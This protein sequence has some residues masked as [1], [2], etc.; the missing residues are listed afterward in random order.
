MIKKNIKKYALFCLIAV[1]ACTM[2]ILVHTPLNQVKGG[3]YT[4]ETENVQESNRVGT[5]ITLASEVDVE[6]NGSVVKFTNG[7]ITYP[8]GKTYGIGK[9]KL[10]DI[11]NYSVKYYYKDGNVLVTAEKIILVT[12]QYYNITGDGTITTVTAEESVGKVLDVNS[13]NVLINNTDG[14]ILRMPEGSQFVY[15]VPIDLSKA[16]ENGIADIITL[17]YRFDEMAIN[18]NPKYD[19]MYNTAGDPSSGIQ[20]RFYYTIV[21]DIAA[22]CKIRLTDAY[23]P[24]NYIELD[25]QRARMEKD[26]TK[27]N[28]KNNHSMTMSAAAAGQALSGCR[29]GTGAGWSSVDAKINGN[30]YIAYLKW[31]RAAMPGGAYLTGHNSQMKGISWGYDNKTNIVYGK[32]TGDGWTVITELDN[33][34]IYPGNPFKGFT[35]GEVYLTIYC[36]T[37]TSPSDGARIDIMSINGVSGK[38]LINQYGQS[39]RV[40]FAAP[41]ITI[42]YDPTKENTIY[43]PFGAEV[44]LPTAFVKEIFSDRS[45]GINVYTN[46]GTSY[47]TLVSTKNNKLKLDQNKIYTVE[48]TATDTS[49]QTGKAYMNICPV[50]SEKAIWVETEELTSVP[51]GTYVTLPEFEIKT[52]NNADKIKYSVKVVGEKETFTFDSNDYEFRPNYTGKYKVI[53]EF[54]DNAYGDTYVYEFDSVGSSEPKFLSKPALPRYVIA[55]EKYNFNDLKAYKFTDNGT[56]EISADAYISVDGGDFAKLNSIN[57]YKIEATNNIRIK[58]VKDGVESE[59]SEAKVTTNKNESGLFRMNKYFV[60]DFTAIDTFNDKG[61]PTTSAVTYVT[62][63]TGGDQVLSFVNLIDLDKF[64]FE[65]KPGIVDNYSSLKVVLTDAYNDKNK[66]EIKYTV[67]GDKYDIEMAGQTVTIGKQYDTN[68]TICALKYSSAH[69]I[70]VADEKQF[71]YGFEEFTSNLCHLDVVLEK[72]SSPSQITIEKVGNHI[73]RGTKTKDDAAPIIDIVTSEGSYVIGSTVTLNVPVFTDIISQIDTKENY[74]KIQHDDGTVIEVEDITK[75]F[76]LKLDKLGTYT[77]V[78]GTADM[79]GNSNNHRYVIIVV[80][81][82]APV[83]TVNNYA[84]DT[85]ILVEYLKVFKLDYTVTDN[86]TDVENIQINISM[87][88]LATSEIIYPTSDTDIPCTV[89]GDFLVRI[90][91]VDEYMNYSC[92]EVYI[93]V[94]GGK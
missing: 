64:E 53:Y 75:T 18:A 39:G 9:H 11:G 52:I 42:N 91:A 49:G 1:L 79:N 51:T 74:V 90:V 82:E 65:F 36:D 70:M 57:G 20:D 37:Y 48:Y 87:E 67:K 63:K 27:A 35:T 30:N 83:I 2:G 16:G 54:S 77:I 45:Y 15:N 59:I 8:N 94:Q 43:A 5:E 26:P 55:G 47:A 58:F 44:D 4:F 68:T 17:S 73:F 29:S 62:N 72:V 66:V 38:E 19:W 24:T 78:Y 6:Y 46:Y 12:D 25:S 14:L 21:K 32:S 76:D 71:N 93:R 84:E 88:N 69:K 33:P 40:D 34:S 61:R 3:T 92:K 85:M 22:R 60:G 81:R 56:E 10:N 80:D 50:Y 7:S 89:E 13:D 31:D 41:E 23:D 86:L 28:F